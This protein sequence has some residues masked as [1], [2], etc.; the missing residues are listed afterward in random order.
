MAMTLIKRINVTSA[1]N[2][3]YTFSSIPQT[4]T[5]LMLIANIQNN[6]TSVD[7][8]FMRFNGDTGNSYIGNVFRYTQVLATNGGYIPQNA[9]ISEVGLGTGTATYPNFSA[10]HTMYIPNYTSTSTAKTLN[11]RWGSHVNTSTAQNATG[12][13]AFQWT[14][15]AAITSISLSGYGTYPTSNT[16]YTLYGIS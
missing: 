9:Y 4:Y 7:G 8:M 1:A 15:T 13:T 12:I 2:I 6:G 3:S 10:G 16:T 14:G 5:D 11:S